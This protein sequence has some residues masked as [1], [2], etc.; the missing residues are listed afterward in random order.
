MPTP[1]WSRRMSPPTSTT[2]LRIGSTASSSTW[3]SSP[4]AN[5]QPTRLDLLSP[6]V[7]L[8][9]EA[10]VVT[11]TLLKTTIASDGSASFS[12]INEARVFAKI[13][14]NWKMVHLHKSPAGA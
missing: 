1:R 2:S 6:R 12:T 8:Y 7:Q 14:G 13:E 4:A 9:G 11:Y 5:G 10:G 3:T